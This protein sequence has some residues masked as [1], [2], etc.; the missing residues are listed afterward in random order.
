M[1]LG[2][3]E[4]RGPQTRY[5]KRFSLEHTLLITGDGSHSLES[6]KFSVAYH[7]T[8]G[9]IQESE[10]VFLQNGLLPK[11]AESP[12]SISILEIGFGTGLN[13]LLVRALSVQH[14]AI[15]FAYATLE[16]YPVP[17][18]VVSQL[19]YPERLACS[20]EVFEELHTAPWDEK[21]ELTRNFRF[22]KYAVDFFAGLRQ[23]A[24]AS[25]QVIFYDAFAPS[26]QPEL[27]APDILELCYQALAPGGCLVT[28]CAKGQFKRDLRKVGFTVEALPGPPGKREMTRAIR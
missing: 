26:S 4:S 16:K 5:K 25:H 7:S 11:L 23:Q 9:A 21:L 17:A 3:S 12:A 24:P 14:P 6:E 10:H 28:Y 2:R 18:T 22:A 1:P 27:W 8:H 15:Q 20:R 13:A 19:N